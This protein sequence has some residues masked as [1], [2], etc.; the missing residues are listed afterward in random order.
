MARL[1]E[2]LDI[3]GMV[4]PNRIAV[5]AMV[6]RLS[7]ED[8]MVNGDIVDRYVR[9][10]AGRVGLIVVEATAIHG[11]KSGP[12]LR[13][14]DDSFIA[15]HRELARRVHDTSDSKVVPQIIHF[16]KVARSGWRQTI[17]MLEQSHIDAIV[18]NFGMAAL[19]AREA[20]YDGIELHSAHAYTLSSFLSRRNP[21]KDRYGGHTLEGRLALFGD[22]MAAVRRRVGADF[23]V[24]VRF[25]ADESIKG[26]YTLPEAQQI[27]LRM[28]D[29]GVDYISLSVGGKFEDAIH[30]PGQPLYPYTGYSGDRCMPGDW[31]PAM[32]NVHLAAGIKSYLNE[33]GHHI[34]V[35]SAG[36]IAEPAQAEGLLRE[37]KADLIGMARQ[38][39][40]DPDWTLKVIQGRDDE[41]IRCVYCNV[42]KDLDERFKKVICFL[43]PKGQLQAPAD[44]VDGQAPNWPAAGAELL[45]GG[46]D[47]RIKLA[48][49]AAESLEGEV[50]GY[51]IYRADAHGAVQCVEAVKGR[52]YVDR[53]A[54]GGQQYRYFV[55]AYDRNGR[56]SPPSETVA[57]TMTMTEHGRNDGE[58]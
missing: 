31:Y 42:C 17:D 43:W 38:L 20:G 53:L 47:G 35:M 9:Y 16:M 34:P 13:L 21:R 49:S 36:K 14:S 8:G 6:T 25:L 22:V 57:I 15:G 32:P 45:G 1:L 2:P 39:L 4:L 29:L 23:P 3:N 44:R 27:A 46:A 18:D 11:A 10:A 54:L 55:R 51:D 30:R 41:I 37:G 40:A 5:P 56:A 26:G 48:W 33:R 7:G 24:G 50:A 28:A 52:R 58:R 12:L 19:R